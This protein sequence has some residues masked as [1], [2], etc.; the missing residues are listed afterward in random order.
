MTALAGD[1]VPGATKAVRRRHPPRGPRQSPARDSLR[2]LSRPSTAVSATTRPTTT[3]TPGSR[4][5][6]RRCSTSAPT[7]AACSPSSRGASW[8]WSIPTSSAGRGG[9][10]RRSSRTRYIDGEYMRETEYAH[11]ISDPT[12]FILTRYMPR[13]SGAMKG[14][15]SIGLLPSADMGHRSVLSLA[16]MLALAGGGG[17]ARD[18]PEDRAG[19]PGVASQAR[20]PSSRRSKTLGFPPLNDGLALAPY[21]VI[22]DNLRG[23]RGTMMD[24]YK[25]PDE[26]REACDSMLRVMLD[27]I[28]MPVEGALNSVIIPLHF[29]SEGFC[30]LQAVRDLLLADAQ[31]ADRRADR[32]GLHAH[33]DDRRRL[34]LAS[35]VS[36]RDTKGEGLRALRHHRHVQGQRRAGRAPLHQRER[37]R[38]AARGGYARTRCG[39]WPSSS[40]TTAGATA[41]SSCLRGPR[42]TTRDRRISRR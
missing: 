22:A 2:L 19:V 3:T 38:L 1:F 30:S 9:A 14:F 36:A 10:A 7:S 33:R 29:G 21:D 17:V 20:L 32:A 37:A 16:E 5:A 42:S 15:G 31:R 23:M 11:L 35:R 34:H 40:S 26:L 41:A 39:T 12:D 28:G 27:S 8:S 25:H 6:R 13:M 24:L 4:P 18:A